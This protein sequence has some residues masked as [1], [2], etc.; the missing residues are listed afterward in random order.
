MLAE[1]SE[2]TSYDDAL[3][4]IL[5]RTKL[6]ESE[7]VPLEKALGRMLTEDAIAPYDL[8]FFDNTAVDGYAICTED[9]GKELPGRTLRLIGK[10]KAGS[11]GNFSIASGETARVLTGS[12]VPHGTGAVVMQEDVALDGE[13]IRLKEP[14]RTGSNLRRQGSELRKGEVLLSR[15][16]LNPAGIG[17]LAASGFAHVTTPRR[18]SVG[19]VVTGDEL[20]PRGAELTPG[21]IFESNGIGLSTALMA[22]GIEQ[23]SVVRAIDDLETTAG[24]MESLL[25]SSD[26]V[27]LSGGMSVGDHDYVRPALRKLS[28]EEHFWGVAIKP[29]KPFLFGSIHGRAIFGLPG[30]PVSAFVTFYLFV[31]PYLLAIQ[32]LPSTTRIVKRKLTQTLDKAAGRQEYVPCSYDDVNVKPY[33]GRASHKSSCLASANG[34]LIFARDLEVLEAGELV[35]VLELFWNERL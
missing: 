10:L 1:R 26:V 23:A 8:P 2:L 5:G 30:N 25:A 12:P 27:L 11:E 6:L 31:R 17:A 20:L 3:K 33:A 35:D 7:S 15:G 34:L 16:V 19:I 28:V 22:L 24:A 13:T 29:G 4:C 21:K 18:P 14:L 9:L 32:D